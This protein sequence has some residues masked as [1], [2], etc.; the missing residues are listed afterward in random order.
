MHIIFYLLITL[1][2]LYTGSI[3]KRLRISRSGTIT[4]PLATLNVVGAIIICYVFFKTYL[5]LFLLLLTLLRRMGRNERKDMAALGVIVTAIGG[6]I[7]AGPAG[8]VIL[9]ALGLL[10]FMFLLPTAEDIATGL[11]T[12]FLKEMLRVLKAARKTGDTLRRRLPQNLRFLVA[13]IEMPVVCSLAIAGVW[14]LMNWL[15]KP[16][17][18]SATEVLFRLAI[19]TPVTLLLY[20]AYLNDVPGIRVRKRKNKPSLPEIP[21]SLPDLQ[22]V[23]SGRAV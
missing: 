1:T 21:V 3:D 22:H 18:L 15:Y 7:A 17:Q 10:L 12:I 23:V 8:W 13:I 11:Y 19:L 14:Q 2:A 5:L 20:R 9:T 16:E 4:T 6:A